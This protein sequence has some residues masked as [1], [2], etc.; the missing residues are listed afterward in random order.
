M[1]KKSDS[2]LAQLVNGYENYQYITLLDPRFV[3][4]RASLKNIYI[5]YINRGSY[6]FIFIY[7]KSSKFS[8]LMFR[9][10]T[11]TKDFTQINN[12][13]DQRVKDYFLFDNFYYIPDDQF[14]LSKY[15]QNIIEILKKID[16]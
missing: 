16:A 6:D 12:F 11:K 1:T 2:P 15:D 14:I 8:R 7:N 4:E 5:Y 10:D 9:I 3:I 13:F